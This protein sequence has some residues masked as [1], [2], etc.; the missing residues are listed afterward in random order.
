MSVSNTFFPDRIRECIQRGN[1]VVDVDGSFL[2]R[3]HQSLSEPGAKVVPLT[4]TPVSPLSGWEAVTE[5][6]HREFTDRIPTVTS[7][8]ILVQ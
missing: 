2:W 3:K 8:I 5:A 4:A 7:G 1:K 6:N